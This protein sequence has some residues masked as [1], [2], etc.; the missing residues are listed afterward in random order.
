MRVHKCRRVGRVGIEPPTGQM[1]NRWMILIG[2]HEGERPCWRHKGPWEGDIIR[3]VTE[4][5]D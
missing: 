5:V 2:T 4:G 1:E 3:H